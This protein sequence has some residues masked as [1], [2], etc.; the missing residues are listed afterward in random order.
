MVVCNLHIV[1]KSTKDVAKSWVCIV[2]KSVL[3]NLLPIEKANN[4]EYRKSIY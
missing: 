1:A 4:D 2:E 3:I